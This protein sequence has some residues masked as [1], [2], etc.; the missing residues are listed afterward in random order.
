MTDLGNRS[1]WSYLI[2]IR[3]ILVLV[4]LAGCLVLSNLTRAAAPGGTKFIGTTWSGFTSPLFGTL[5]NQI[6]PENAGKWGN[7]EPQKGVFLWHQLDAM[8]ALAKRRHLI[9]KQ[10]NMIWGQNQPH[11]ITD[12]N[13]AAAVR[14]WFAA[15][16]RRYG[17]RTAL[18]DVVNEPLQSPPAYRAGLPG[19]NTKWGWVIWCYRLARQYFPHT[20][21]LI[22]DYDILDSTKNTLRYARLIALLQKR[23]LIDGI[24]CQAHGLEHVQSPVIRKNLA[25]LSRLHVPIYI[26]EYDLNQKSDSGQLAQMKR[27][28]PIFWKDPHVAGVT[29]WD[30]KQGHTW[31]RFTWLVHRNGKPRPAMVWLRHY[32]RR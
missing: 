25:I 6:T 26:S 8:Y 14:T 23:G 12:R 27:Q 2:N 1:W 3:Y 30:F 4:V 5:F 11:W 22:N 15:F 24:G 28:F 9:V 10:H 13:A 18:M 29:F 31:K 21:L 16:A 7:V 20:K 32:L 19:G 17:T